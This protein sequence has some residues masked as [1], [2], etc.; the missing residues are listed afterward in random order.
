VFSPDLRGRRGRDAR[1][2]RRNRQ[3]TSGAAC[4]RLASIST[5]IDASSLHTRRFS[6]FVRFQWF[7]ARKIFPPLDFRHSGVMHTCRK[8]DGGAS[9]GRVPPED[10][11]CLSF[12]AVSGLEEAI[13]NDS[14]NSTCQKEKS[15]LFQ[16]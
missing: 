7:A 3:E 8:T 4:L 10:D 15:I 6:H 13:K 9:G 2:R 12:I 14:M 11:L 5:C 1:L 16:K